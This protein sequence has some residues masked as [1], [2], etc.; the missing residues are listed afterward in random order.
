MSA[1]VPDHASMTTKSTHRPVRRVL[2]A[3]AGAA[4]LS[5]SLLGTAGA[6]SAAPA[7]KSSAS[8]DAFRWDAKTAGKGD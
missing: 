4:V 8:T 1:H 6:A 7:P 2:T 3:L 5:A